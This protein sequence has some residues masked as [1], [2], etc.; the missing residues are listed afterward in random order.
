M[1]LLS[2]AAGGAA[3][4]LARYGLGGWLQGWAGAWLPWGTFGVNALGSLL[5][6]FALRYLEGVPASP[7]VRALVAIGLLGAFTTFSTYAYETV[8]L[9]REGAWLRAGLY[10]LGSLAFG[11]VAVAL[12]LGVAEAV[13]RVRG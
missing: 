6:G 5:I 10:S 2:I 13:L 8:A 7:E 3:G 11:L 12:G 4:A 9:L 1:M